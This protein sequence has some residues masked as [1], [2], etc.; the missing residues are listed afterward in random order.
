M[1]TTGQKADET[2]APATSGPMTDHAM[3]DQICIGGSIAATSSAATASQNQI[4][5]ATG[6]GSACVNGAMIRSES[7]KQH[8]AQKAQQINAGEQHVPGQ[9]RDPGVTHIGCNQI[10]LMPEI[11]GRDARGA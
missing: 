10:D 1:L 4:R 11:R 2:G 7:G 5:A 9:R 6:R 8:K 3:F